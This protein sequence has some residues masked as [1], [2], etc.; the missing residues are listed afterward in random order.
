MGMH[1]WPRIEPWNCYVVVDFFKLHIQL[2]VKE[3]IW[4]ALEEL[5]GGQLEVV[6]AVTYWVWRE[7]CN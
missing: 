7:R 4:L 6:M 5:T 3:A 1:G 2:D